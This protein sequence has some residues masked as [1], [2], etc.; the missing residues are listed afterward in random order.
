MS[1]AGGYVLSCV[2]V[3]VVQKVVRLPPPQRRPSTLL[4][5]HWCAGVATAPG[6]G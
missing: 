5:L 3:V 2:L 1:Y 4:Q 6:K